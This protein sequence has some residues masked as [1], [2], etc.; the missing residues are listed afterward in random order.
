MIVQCKQPI[1]IEKPIQCLLTFSCSVGER[2]VLQPVL[3]S[4]F[5]GFY[6]LKAL[7]SDNNGNTVYVLGHK[8]IFGP[9]QSSF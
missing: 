4:F 1:N 5:F 2:N 3:S 6:F 8:Y 7:Q 9:S